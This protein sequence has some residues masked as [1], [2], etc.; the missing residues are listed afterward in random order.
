MEKQECTSTKGP[1]GFGSKI[2]HTL[3][4]KLNK[5]GTSTKKQVSYSYYLQANYKMVE[6]SFGYLHWF[7]PKYAHFLTPQH[8]SKVDFAFGVS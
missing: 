8:C 4:F 3:P 1:S 7:Y 6:P 5:Q 2:E